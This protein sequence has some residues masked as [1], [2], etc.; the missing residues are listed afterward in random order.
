LTTSG[1]I[2]GVVNPPVDPPK[3]SFWAGNGDA[4]LDPEEWQAKQKRQLGTWWMDWIEWLGKR[5]GESVN[6]PRIGSSEY[7]ALADAPGTYVLET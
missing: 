6:P 7:P 1:H 2:A 5:C 4:S 3:R